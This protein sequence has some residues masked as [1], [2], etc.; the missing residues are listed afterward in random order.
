MHHH[1]HHHLHRHRH[2]HH[3]EHHHGGRKDTPRCTARLRCHRRSC[4]PYRCPCTA[5]TAPSGTSS[6]SA[7]ESPSTQHDP[8]ET[9]HPGICLSPTKTTPRAGQSHPSPPQ[10]QSLYPPKKSLLHVFLVPKT[11]VPR[12]RS[13]SPTSK[14]SPRR[15]PKTNP[16]PSAPSNTSSQQ[17]NKNAQ[18]STN[19][20]LT[21][22]PRKAV[23][24]PSS[25]PPIQWSHH[26]TA[27]FSRNRA[28]KM[29]IFTR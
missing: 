25:S 24:P 2:R 28:R 19:N 6:A 26:T 1:L 11:K 5:P 12:Y 15:S 27:T 14:S 21:T 8:W 10:Q 29:N 4:C 22:L 13:A 18:M 23:S 3:H 9:S 20:T 17:P 7:I 16:N